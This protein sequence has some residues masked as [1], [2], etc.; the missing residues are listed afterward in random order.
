MP[1]RPINPRTNVAA[2][3]FGA[4]PINESVNDLNNIR[5]IIE[6]PNITNPRDSICESNK[7]CSML[8]YNINIPV[9][10][11]I[12]G[13]RFNLLSRSVLILSISSFL[14]RSFLES[15]TLILIL[16]SLLSI[17]INGLTAISLTFS[18]ALLYNRPISR[19]LSSF[20]SL[21]LSA[22]LIVD[23]KDKTFPISDCESR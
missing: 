6:I 21:I 8:L 22:T 19:L 1:I 10:V 14:R 15:N 23:A 2:R 7:L 18:G 13:S 9:T 16:A 5:N 3:R 17:D 12:D 4:I 11:N 20:P